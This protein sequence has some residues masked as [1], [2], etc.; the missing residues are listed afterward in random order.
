MDSTQEEPGD[1]AVC[2]LYI[3]V[4]TNYLL[5]VK[6]HP[7]QADMEGSAHVA[8]NY[9]QLHKRN[10]ELENQVEELQRKLD[11]KED[12][13]NK[14]TKL[15][16]H[17]LQNALQKENEAKIKL[18]ES[19]AKLEEEKANLVTQLN[20]IQKELDVQTENAITFKKGNAE[21]QEEV[22]YLKAEM[23]R[24]QESIEGCVLTPKHHER[25]IERLQTELDKKTAQ[26]EDQVKARQEEVKMLNQQL[27]Q[28]K[29]VSD[30]QIEELSAEL[31][32]KDEMVAELEQRVQQADQKKAEEIEQLQAKL[33]QMMKQKAENEEHRIEAEVKRR[34]KCLD[35]VAS[36]QIHK[37]KS[38]I[39]GLKKDKEKEANELQSARNTVVQLQEELQLARKEKELCVQSLQKVRDEKLQG[40]Q[41]KH[42][43]ETKKLTQ[44]YEQLLEEKTRENECLQ[45]HLQRQP[46]LDLAKEESLEA[47]EGSDTELVKQLRKELQQTK[48]E[49]E[50]EHLAAVEQH[51]K[52]KG[53][54]EK[55]CADLS[56]LQEQYARLMIEANAKKELALA[57]LCSS[58]DDICSTLE[59]HEGQVSRR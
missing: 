49:K 50:R 43:S 22:D 3:S 14:Q 35:P 6:G 8:A 56:Q 1:K 32:E 33:E 10:E 7:C 41:H 9:E 13:E 34:V 40:I 17:E 45:R 25:E 58:S 5:Q 44:R 30:K 36:G 18:K 37:L 11:Q 24:T 21:L 4:D 27:K 59:T 15:H 2:T 12:I 23:K 52:L 57:D 19:E 55:A 48:L 31:Q 51:M 28:C 38:E 53:E 29:E 46:T 39:A 16:E 26:H 20:E 42:A 47:K 54:Y